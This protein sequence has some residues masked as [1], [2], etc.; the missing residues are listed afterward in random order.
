MRPRKREKKAAKGT[1]VP[2]KYVV[3]LD[4]V[5]T[6]CLSEKSGTPSWI[7]QVQ[8]RD[9][10]LVLLWL[11]P[12]MTGDLQPLDVNFNRPFKA[13]YRPALA[14]L[15]LYQS[16]EKAK[17]GE[18]TQ[19]GSTSRADS[20][21]H[22]LKDV[23]IK[24]IIAAYK[25]VPKDQIEKGWTKAGKFVYEEN[26]VPDRGSG[27]HSAWDTHTQ[28][29]TITAFNTGTLFHEGMRGGVSDV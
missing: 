11:P 16:Q 4:G 2:R 13:T 22:K 28:N 8:E 27:Y 18:D 5:S 14:R 1:K 21:A 10:D 3:I 23:V 6:H 7:T 29:E 15:K 19:K 20:S 25:S 26:D 24:A 12:N 17:T 9:P